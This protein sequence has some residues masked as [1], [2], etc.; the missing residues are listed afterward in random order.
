MKDT[1]FGLIFTVFGIVTLSK[2]ALQFF[3]ATS[4]I[5]NITLIILAIASVVY[6]VKKLKSHSMN[7]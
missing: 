5:D 1:I 7:H 4:L 3:N 6:G 2:V